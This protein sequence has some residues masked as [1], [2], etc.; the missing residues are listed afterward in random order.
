MRKNQKRNLPRLILQWLI[1]VYLLYLAT[2]AFFVKEFVPDFEAYC[3]FGG[4]QALSSYLLNNSLACSMTT[5]QITMGIML[6]V[7]IVLFSKLFCAYICPIGTISEWLG[8]VGDKFKISLKI[9]GV[10][11]KILRSLKYLLLFITFYFT[12]DSNELFCRKYDPFFAIA[13]GF[14][15]DTVLLYALPALA[16]VIVGSLL[17]RLF[18]CK[19]FCPFGAVSNIFKFSWFLVSLLLAYFIII[20]AG[21]PLSYV[22]PLAMACAGGYVLEIWGE[23]FNFLPVAKITRNESSCTNC[24]L[25]SRKCPQA[26]DVA[27]MKVVDAADCNLCGDCLEVCPE[28]ETLLINRKSGLKRMPLIAVIVLFL[29]AL[30]W[31]FF[32]ELPTISQ[33]WGTPEEIKKAT[34]FTKS[35]LTEIKCFSSSMAFAT[36]MKEVKG[37]LGVATYVSSHRVEIYYDPTLLND[38]IIQSELFKPQK[39]DIHP[40]GDS[41]RTVIIATCM[42]ENFFDP[43]DFRNLALLLKEKTGAL[44]VESEFSCPVT[45]RIYLPGNKAWDESILMEILGTKNLNMVSE[46]RQSQTTFSFKQV[47]KPVFRTIS[48]ISYKQR[49]FESYQNTF[50]WRSGYS[51]GI[52]DTLIVPAGTNQSIPDSLAYFVSHLSNDTGVV[53]FQSSM[54]STANILFKIIYIDSLTTTAKIL[55]SMRSDSLTIN[56]EGGEVG[57]VL[58]RFKF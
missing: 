5:T 16:I 57:K 31:S 2:R 54:D 45:V 17:F 4:I 52:L 22:W 6:I 7:G 8:N 24:Q 55:E 48:M 37:V 33:R 13:T 12:L 27:K 46:G 51:A 23:K 25:C 56:Y 36:K 28:K 29:V 10:T 49:M 32:W 47:G 40:I 1:I 3:P 39:M 20:K 58:N 9:S 21:I 35:G 44:G 53:G 43:S 26:I 30:F 11:D 15:L 42:L 41:V 34:V 50:N 19:Y 14:S 18:W 38:T